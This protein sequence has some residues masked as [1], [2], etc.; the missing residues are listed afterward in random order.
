MSFRFFDSRDRPLVDLLGRQ[1]AARPARSAG[2]RRVRRR[3][4]GSSRVTTSFEGRPIRVRFTWSRIDDADSAL[5]AG[6]LRGRRHDLGDELDRGLHTRGGGVVTSRC[7]WRRRTRSP[8]TTATWRSTRQPGPSIGS[9]RPR[10]S[11]TTSRA[12]TPRWRRTTAGARATG[13][14]GRVP[15]RRA[16]AR[17]RARLRDPPP[18]RERGVPLPARPDVAERQRALADR[19]GEA[20]RRR[21]RLPP[22]GRRERPP[23]DVLRLGARRRRA[24][25]ARLV[26][27]TSRSARDDAAR[28]T[29][30]DDVLRGARYDPGRRHEGAERPCGAAESAGA[31]QAAA[32]SGMCPPQR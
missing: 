29:Y 13:A 1:P 6:V 18:L 3:R 16:A 27:R 10:S 5:G 4:R 8:P 15:A 23:A 28:R 11:G 17:R 26:A 32:A 22:V 31:G 21:P 12:R 24:R 25:A 19:L 9:A 7:R 14:R 20:R 30:L 2:D